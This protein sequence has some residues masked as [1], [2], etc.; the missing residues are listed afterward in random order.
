MIPPLSVP[1]IIQVLRTR[2]PD[3]LVCNRC[4]LLLAT[5]RESYAKSN[6]TDEQRLAFICAECRLEAAEAARVYAGRVAQAAVAREAAAAARAAAKDAIETPADH[7]PES[8]LDDRPADPH[9]QRGLG[10]GFISPASRKPAAQ[11]RHGVKG[12]R[13]RKHA[14]ALTARREAR[15]AYRARQKQPASAALVP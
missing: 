2:Y 6:L 11:G 13:P 15:R 8:V 3:A 14:T 1:D 12:G 7:L 10:G 5:K 9:E 4:G